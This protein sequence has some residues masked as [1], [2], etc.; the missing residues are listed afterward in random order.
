MVDRIFRGA[1]VVA[2]RCA[3]AVLVGAL[4]VSTAR[5]EPPGAGPVGW[6][7]L[8]VAEGGAGLDISV[9]YAV[10]GKTGAL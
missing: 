2:A 7:V 3:T 4:L 8:S 1:S 5:A 6:R 10:M 9:H